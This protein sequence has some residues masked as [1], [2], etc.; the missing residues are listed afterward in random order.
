MLWFTEWRENLWCD[1]D[2]SFTIYG[3]FYMTMKIYEYC[4]TVM[5]FFLWGRSDD[6]CDIRWKRLFSR[7]V[8]VCRCFRKTG[9][10]HNMA[11]TIFL[12]YIF[13]FSLLY[14]VFDSVPHNDLLFDLCF[15]FV[16][17]CSLLYKNMHSLYALFRVCL[18]ESVFLL[19]E[20]C[21]EK[22]TINYFNILQ[23]F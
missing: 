9:D 23:F 14:V 8:G 16:C 15:L 19:T 6:N 12:R 4:F 22:I 17:V 11:E 18:L 5:F 20:L 10:I 7:W 2:L 3:F 13:T 21:R 1:F